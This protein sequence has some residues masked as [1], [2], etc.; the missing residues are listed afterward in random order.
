MTMTQ[1]TG[2]A[3]LALALATPT[4]ALEDP[5]RPPDFSPGVAVAAVPARTHS[6]DSI[7]IGPERRVAVVDGI[8]R[9]EGERFDGLTLLKIHPGRVE[10][11][12]RDQTRTLHWK[13]PPQV[14]VLR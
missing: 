3:L 14:R 13:T 11:S 9:T 12:D 8:A 4:I 7:M 6:L 10:L 5:T 2:F 1:M